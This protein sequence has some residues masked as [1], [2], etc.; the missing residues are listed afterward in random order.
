MIMFNRFWHCINENGS[1]Q[2]DATI[3]EWL[4][5]N[6][7]QVRNNKLACLKLLKS[8]NIE[9]REV[10]HTDPEFERYPILVTEASTMTPVA[11][12]RQKWIVMRSDDFKMMAMCLRTDRGKEIRE[13]YIAIETLFKMYCEYTFEFLK[14]QSD[15]QMSE[16][17]QLLWESRRQNSNIGDEVQNTGAKLRIAREV[18]VPPIYEKPSLMNWCVVI[19]MASSYVPSVNDPKYIREGKPNV[20]ILRGQERYIN[21]R[22]ASVKKFGDGTNL[23]AKIV[24]RFPSPN[25]IDL[26]N[27]LKIELSQKKIRKRLRFNFSVW[28]K[29]TA[30]GRWWWWWFFG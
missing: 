9:Y 12:N 22:L 26:N 27:R 11:L 15:Q 10:K 28:R 30:T 19:E 1:V 25:A 13:Y 14:R 24:K 8:H 29:D 20:V 21:S 16:R 2:L 18:V 6:H 3:Y 4:G 7:K 5:Y 17:D 23:G